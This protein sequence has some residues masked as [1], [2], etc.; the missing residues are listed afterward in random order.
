MKYVNIYGKKR[1]VGKKNVRFI[2]IS[3]NIPCIL[4]GKD[5]NIPFYTASENLKKVMRY[6][7]IHGVN[8]KIEGYD[9]NIK[10][11]QK[12]IQFDP[13]SD[14]ILHVDFYKIE[15]SKPIKLSLP[16]KFVGRPI[17]VTKGGEYYSLIRK[18]KIKAFP[19][20]IPEF[21][22]IDISSLDIGD[23]IIVKDLQNV[24]YS[25]LDPVQTLIARVK[26]SRTTIKEE[27]NKNKEDKKQQKNK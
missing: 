13:V 20:D 4:Y 1:N 16:V 2:R 26:N 12:E 11:V 9:K 6:G 3:E 5:I 21:I 15:E 24:K 8:I 17:G 7:D 14:E 25:I 10:A 18:L 19:S 22:K 23:R 27:D